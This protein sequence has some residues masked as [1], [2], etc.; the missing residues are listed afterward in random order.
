MRIVLVVMLLLATGARADQAT[1]EENIGNYQAAIDDLRARVAAAGESKPQLKVDLAQALILARSDF[2][3]MSDLPEARRIL[4]GL[5]DRPALRA[6]VQSAYGALYLAMLEPHNAAVAYQASLDAAGDP[7]TQARAAANAAVAHL[8]EARSADDPSTAVTSGRDMNAKAWDLAEGLPG[9]SATAFLYL[10]IGQSAEGLASFGPEDSKLRLTAYAAYQRA[11]EAAPNDQVVQSYGLGYSGHLYELEGHFAEAQ[12]LTNR[13]E[14]GAQQLRLPNLLYLWQWQMGR[15]LKAEGDRNGAIAA[16]QAAVTSLRSIQ[17]DLAAGGGNSPGGIT[18]RQAAGDVYDELADLLLQ[19]AAAESDDA[20]RQVELAEARDTVE[21]LKTAELQ[22]YFQD[23]CERL[24]EQRR[25]GIE[26]LD[27]RTAVVYFVPLADRVEILVGISSRIEEF[28]TPIGVDD[29][30]RVARR[31]R[32]EVRDQS[33]EEYFV[34][35]QKLYGWLVAP[36][37][38]LLAA[39]TIDTLVFV[40]D[41]VLRSVPMAALADAEGKFLIQK[42]SVAVSPG[43]RLTEARDYP[44]TGGASLLISGLSTA[45]D[46]FPALKYVPEELRQINNSSGGRGKT[47]LN[48][49]FVTAQ[50]DIQLRTMDYSIVHIASHGHFGASAQDTYI[51]DYDGR[52]DLDDLERLIEPSKY[53]QRPIDLLTLSACETAAGDDRSV[54]GLAGIAVKAGALSAVAT[55]W[56]VNDR[57]S[58]IIVPLF[59]SHLG[60]T[61]FTK[62]KALAAAQVEMLTRPELKAYRH[63]FFWAPYLLV[64]NWL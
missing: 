28:S 10:T 13:A 61:G 26:S 11:M 46:G 3:G 41:G 16:Y 52:L 22:N 57:S 18:F 32:V 44:S 60:E 6:E 5:A 64:G 40:P 7:A 2:M 56:A 12:R 20:T 24:L 53:R 43:L 30:N 55:L 42:Y 58:S 63:P 39:R 31:F 48:E 38:S 1:V 4:D 19:R 36:I 49:K 35:G 29:L 59:Y 25:K 51:L 9:G 45:K 54:L 15:L 37:E 62:A 21:N 23:R 27:P 34:D 33:S 14:F 50:L 47:L 17:T 8:A